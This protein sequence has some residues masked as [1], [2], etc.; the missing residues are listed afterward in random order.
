LQI[1]DALSRFSVPDPLIFSFRIPGPTS[2]V[3]RGVPK[4]NIPF[5]CC[6]RFLEQ[7]LRIAQFR[8]DNIGTGNKDS[9]DKVRKFHKKGAG[10]GIRKKSIPDPRGKKA[11]DL[12]SGS[13]TLVPHIK[14]M[15]GIPV[16]F[17]I[18]VVTNICSINTRVLQNLHILRI[19]LLVPVPVCKGVQITALLSKYKKF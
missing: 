1:R 19:L 11:P 4:V 16:F 8:N 14:K 3:K 17:Y 5:S 18:F 9:E 2:Y 15:R 7:I 13:A 10:Y 6:L 12:G